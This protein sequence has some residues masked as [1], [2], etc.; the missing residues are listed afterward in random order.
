MVVVVA[1]VVVVVA[2]G[3]EGGTS[4]FIKT[5]PLLLLASLCF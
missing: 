3:V 2:V 5:A 1:V 4:A